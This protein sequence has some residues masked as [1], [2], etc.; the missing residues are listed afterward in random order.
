MGNGACSGGDFRHRYVTVDGLLI[1]VVSAGDAQAPA[2]LLLHGWPENWSTWSEVMRDL[3]ADLHVIALDLPGIGE[4]L[5]APPAYDK[6]TLAGILGRLMEVIDLGDVTVVGSDI[7][8]MI[9]YAASRGAIPRVR[10]AVI[11]SVAVPGV[12]PWSEVVANTA[13]WHFAFHAVPHLP[14]H[15]VTGRVAE[16]F[17]FFYD[18]L[19]A[20]SRRIP[21][22]IRKRFV[23]A[24]A[25]PAALHTGFEW[26]R[27][28]ARDARDNR[29]HRHDTETPVLYL[30]GSEDRGLPLK[31]YV[32]G[33]RDSG[34][35]NVTGGEIAGSGHFIA[36]EQPLALAREIRR[37]VASR[38]ARANASLLTAAAF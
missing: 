3:S 26:Y 14:E 32:A 30:R 1:H 8:G 13:I 22:E 21:R 33:L 15:L 23:D 20:D 27:A 5:T 10:Q 34:L 4:S 11:T 38:P 7:G 9:A 24:Y 25:G 12:D 16:Y 17:D 28:F 36:I 18:Q 2:V 35:R 29:D 19:S 31:R 6:R 37:F